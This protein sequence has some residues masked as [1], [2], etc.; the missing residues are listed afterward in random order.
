M[1]DGS[2]QPLAHEANT[3]NVKGVHPANARDNPTPDGAQLWLARNHSREQIRRVQ[4]RKDCLHGVASGRQ[5]VSNP[6]EDERVWLGFVAKIATGNERAYQLSAH[7]RLGCWAPV[8]QIP[9]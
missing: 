2:V 9:P 4:S 7:D 6:A 8:Y 1:N 5:S 3:P